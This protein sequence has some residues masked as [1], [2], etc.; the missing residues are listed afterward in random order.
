MM[1]DV[2]LLHYGSSNTTAVFC[3][4]DDEANP[5]QTLQI[6]DYFYLIYRKKK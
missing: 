5:T 3:Y 4:T 2:W 6:I 1:N